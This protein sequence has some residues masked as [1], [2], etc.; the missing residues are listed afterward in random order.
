VRVTVLS[1]Q[2]LAGF[3]VTVAAEIDRTLTEQ[4]LGL[5]CGAELVA[6]LLPATKNRSGVTT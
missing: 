6:A 5:L 4:V 1:G 2:V 3:I